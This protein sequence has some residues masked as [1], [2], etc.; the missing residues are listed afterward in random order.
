MNL[1]RF[2]PPHAGTLTHAEAPGEKGHH[3][4]HTAEHCLRSRSYGNLDCRPSTCNRAPPPRYHGIAL[5]GAGVDAPCPRGALTGIGGGAD[6]A[7]RPPAADGAGGGASSGALA[8]SG[9]GAAFGLF[10]LGGAL[11]ANW[12]A[13]NLSLGPA[14][15]VAHLALWVAACLANAAFQE[16]LVRG[17]AFDSLRESLGVAGATLITTALFVAFHP[18]AFESGPVA[19]LQ[20]AA[21]SLLLTELRLLAGGLVAPTAAHFA[22][23]AAGG[24]GLGVVALADDY[25]HVFS[26]SVGVGTSL[27]TGVMGVEG[28]PWTL[29][30]TIAFCIALAVFLRS[31]RAD[32]AR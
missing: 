25:P 24:I 28:S 7:L 19:V 4:L 16:L 5:H 31:R 26:C 3:D 15:P 27:S 2:A 14:A 11:G 13:G 30:V 10:W 8:A 9:L 20:M 21:A 12:L 23:N 22:W 29:V 18:G 17:Y 32:G 1:R 6:G